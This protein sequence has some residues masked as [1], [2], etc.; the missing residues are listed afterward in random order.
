[1]RTGSPR[2]PM[3]RRLWHAFSPV[4]PPTGIPCTQDSDVDVEVE[5]GAGD[6]EYISLLSERL[7]SLVDQVQPD[8][9]FYQV[10]RRR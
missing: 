2:W 7:P 3:V 5:E 9:I 8:L 6:E 4:S 10:P 1:M